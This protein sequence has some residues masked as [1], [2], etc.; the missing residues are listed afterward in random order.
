MDSHA[1][2]GQ[3]DGIDVE[4][5]GADTDSSL[6]AQWSSVTPLS[7]R[8]SW[9]IDSLKSV[10]QLSNLEENWDGH[11]SPPISRVAV[12]EMVSLLKLLELAWISTDPNKPNICDDV[13][14]AGL[15]QSRLEHLRVSHVVPVP[16]GGLQAEWQVD[17]RELEIEILPDRS[18]EYLMCL[19]TGEM[20]SGR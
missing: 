2:F 13:L 18:V 7:S 1:A 3:I 14:S 5:L 19:D 20:Q 16:G 4:D 10:F 11:G 17:N 8:Q 9:L 12:R 6:G 15:R